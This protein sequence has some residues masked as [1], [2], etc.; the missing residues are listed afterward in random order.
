MV[1]T[2]LLSMATQKFPVTAQ[3]G[4]RYFCLYKRYTVSV[5]VRENQRF[6]DT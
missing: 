6:I 4:F 2:T 1:V 5:V 3:I